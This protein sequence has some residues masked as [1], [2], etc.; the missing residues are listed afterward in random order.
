M[1][2]PLPA[3]LLLLQLY[4]IALGSCFWGWL[5]PANAGVAA[6]AATGP[7]AADTGSASA[8]SYHLNP[9]RVLY[10]LSPVAAELPT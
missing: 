3:L 5:R 9:T 7:S 6:A 1:L 4:G 2:L 10:N 8:S